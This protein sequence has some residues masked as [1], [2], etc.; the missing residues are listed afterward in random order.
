MKRKVC[1][2][3]T[4]AMCIQRLETVPYEKS[5]EKLETTQ[6]A[7]KR[8][9]LGISERDKIRNTKIT[10]RKKV[11]DIVKELVKMKW[12]FSGNVVRYDDN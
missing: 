2:T 5:A 8:N 4:F 11:R 10:R 7:M 6:R 3:C 9:V 12:R 1:D